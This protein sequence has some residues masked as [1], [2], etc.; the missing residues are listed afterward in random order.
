MK[1]KTQK[2]KLDPE[3]KQKWIDALRS[4]EYK[5]GNGVLFDIEDG[6]KQFCC[7]GILGKV[8]NIPELS[9]KD[10]GMPYYLS[11]RQQKKLPKWARVS[12]KSEDANDPTFK[13]F[14]KLADY[15]DGGKS[16]KWI[17]SYI[18]RYL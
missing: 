5:Q 14:E 6:G 12:N 10:T 7:L 11:E 16:F 1:T 4:G 8:C 13:L 2:L 15:N 3:T 17:A 18:E 9:M